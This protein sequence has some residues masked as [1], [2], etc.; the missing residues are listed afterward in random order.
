MRFVLYQALEA[1]DIDGDLRHALARDDMP[2]AWGHRVIE[3]DDDPFALF[4]NGGP[5][6]ATGMIDRLGTMSFAEACGSMGSF[7][8]DASWKELQRRLR[9]QTITPTDAEWAFS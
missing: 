4:R 8:S 7:V 5:S 2:G 6:A 1:A 9:E 3:C